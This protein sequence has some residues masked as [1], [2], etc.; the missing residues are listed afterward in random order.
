MTTG[1]INQVT[2]IQKRLPRVGDNTPKAESE[3]LADPKTTRAVT[4]SDVADVDRMLR[5]LSFLNDPHPHRSQ[6]ADTG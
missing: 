2:I 4:T 1:R 6:E 5:N 3:T